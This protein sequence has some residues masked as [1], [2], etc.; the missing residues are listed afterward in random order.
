VIV[1]TASQR[2]QQ[3]QRRLEAWAGF[4]SDRDPRPLVLLSPQVREGPFPD[5]KAKL[6]FVRGLVEAGPG[7]PAA[8]LRA[9]RPSRQ[10]AGPPLEPLV[11]TAATP[12]T[13]EFWTDR[14]RR[15]LPA[16]T[17]HA[18]GIPEPV[19]QVL[20]PATSHQAWRPPGLED[21]ELY[22]NNSTAALG[23]DGRTLTLRFTGAPRGFADYP[24][25]EVLEAGAAVALLPV[26]VDTGPPPWVL[27]ALIGE[28]REVTVILTRPLGARVLL[29]GDAMP[30]LV[31]C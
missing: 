6:A 13:A 22:G 24:R 30:V 3:A 31:R 10:D 21:Q 18:H 2:R 9:L 11:V 27:R 29:D 14:G 25:A 5:A 28:W 26:E 1:S 17:I 15:E 20:D 12:G 4:P 19:C 8:L 23:A 16:W 7:F